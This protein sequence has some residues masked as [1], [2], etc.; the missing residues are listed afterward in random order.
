MN[1]TPLCGT[2][3]YW[4]FWCTYRLF[5]VFSLYMPIA[6]PWTCFFPPRATC[7]AY[8][9]SGKGLNWSC[10]YRPIPRPMSATYTTAHGNIR[11][12]THW[13]RPGDRAYI[14]MD[15]RWVCFHWATAGTP[16]MLFFFFC[17]CLCSV[18]SKD[19]FLLYIVWLHIKCLN[20]HR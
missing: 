19:K 5:S 9:G 16:W 6:M 4:E 14:L 2:I 7:A 17:I 3:I 13:A 15:I 20:F 1:D 18:V 11:S 12:L 8:G 10:S